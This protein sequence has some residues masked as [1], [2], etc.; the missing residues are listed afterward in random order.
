[1]MLRLATAWIL[2]LLGSLLLLLV[3]LSGMLGAT[4]DTPCTI[5]TIPVSSTEH[6]TAIE[7][8]CGEELSLLGTANAQAWPLLGLSHFL[9]APRAAVNANGRLLFTGN[10]HPGFLNHRPTRTG[11]F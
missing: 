4:Y 11:C 5:T 1:M 8:I 10:S 2:T 6:T 7:T 3:S 9:N